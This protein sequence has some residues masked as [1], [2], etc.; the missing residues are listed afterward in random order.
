MFQM[1]TE[2]VVV[3]QK[4]GEAGYVRSGEIV[5]GQ[6]WCLTTTK[7]KHLAMMFTAQA[8]EEVIRAIHSSVALGYYTKRAI[9]HCH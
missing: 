4:N 7:R 9:S 6:F 2:R 8:K 3:E 1:N 5:N